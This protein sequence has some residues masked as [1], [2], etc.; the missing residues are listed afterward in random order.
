MEDGNVI[1]MGFDDVIMCYIVVFWNMVLGV[2][3]LGYFDGYDILN[4]I[5]NMIEFV[6]CGFWIGSGKIEFNLFGGFLDD[7]WDFDKFIIFILEII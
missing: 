7:W 3:S 5:K 1:L 6:M 4:G 2:I